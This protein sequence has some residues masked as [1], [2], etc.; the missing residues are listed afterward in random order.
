MRKRRPF[1][2]IALIVLF[3]VGT[4]ASFIAAVSLM[5]RGSFLEPIWRLNAQARAGFDRLGSW[6]IVLMT[7]VCAACLLS[8]M[9]LWWRR[10]WGYWLAVFMLLMNFVGDLV[11]VVSG[12]EPRAV[13]GIPIV[14]VILG[15]LLRSRTRNYFT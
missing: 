9:G 3:A 14:L 11:N 1:G 6:A 13:I 4:F 12:S 15:F 7:I 2:I 8:A 5:F 10:R